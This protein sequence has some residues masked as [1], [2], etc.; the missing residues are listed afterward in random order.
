MIVPILDIGR[1]T[2][3]WMNSKSDSESRAIIGSRV[4][5][6]MIFS[7]GFPDGTIDG[8]APGKSASADAKAPD[9]NRLPAPS[10][11]MA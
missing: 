7:K 3:L 11:K 5:T 4:G 10:A 6:M 8:D 1:S 9:E 2:P